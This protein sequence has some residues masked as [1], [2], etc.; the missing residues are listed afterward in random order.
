MARRPDRRSA[1]A[2]A[3][4]KLYKTARWQRM[5][6]YQLT[7]EP[8]C[9]YCLEREEVTAATVCDHIKAHGGDEQLFWDPENLQSLCAPLPRRREAAH[10]QGTER[11][12]L[13]CR[14]VA[15]LTLRNNVA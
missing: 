2:A 7:M 11:G 13:W 1:E 15:A 10:R 6:E 4:R 3:Y 9:R 14:W 5:R 8:L 12:P